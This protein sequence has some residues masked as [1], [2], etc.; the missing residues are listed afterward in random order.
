M[1]EVVVVSENFHKNRVWLPCAHT[2]IHSH[3]PTPTHT[4]PHPPTPTHTHPHPHTLT[5]THTH[6]L[7]KISRFGW[8]DIKN[9]QKICWERI[10]TLRQ[11]YQSF[12]KSFKY[13]IIWTQKPSIIWTLQLVMKESVQSF[14][15]CLLY[16]FAKITTMLYSL[17]NWQTPK[18]T[19]IYSVELF[20]T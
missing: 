15:S 3:P 6:P 19:V 16:L 20:S 17:L 7:L 11:F 1:E 10:R 13:K 5:P 12:V 8:K 9:S 2:H 4:H 14:E 18:C